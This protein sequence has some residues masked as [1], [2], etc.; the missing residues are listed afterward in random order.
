[1][2]ARFFATAPPAALLVGLAALAAALWALAAAVPGRLRGPARGAAWGGALLA[3]AALTWWVV[4]RNRAGL[5]LPAG[6]VSPAIDGWRAA[7]T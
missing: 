4:A 2:I 1:M 3:A 6:A 5:A 7:L